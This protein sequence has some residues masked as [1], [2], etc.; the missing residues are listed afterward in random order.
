[1]PNVKMGFEGQVL[2]SNTPGSTGATLLENTRDVNYNLETEDGDTTVRGDGSA[3][4]I[5][6][7]DPTRRVISIDWQMIN[8]IT[9][10]HFEALRVKA[11]TGGAVAV[12]LKDHV[13]GKGFDGDVT[14]AMSNPMPLAGEQ[15]VTFTAKPTRSYGRAPQTYV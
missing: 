11:A 2:Y 15:V 14:L 12:R 3:P 4:P 7:S 8:D 10:T 6:T 5:A 1:M 9:D 13:T